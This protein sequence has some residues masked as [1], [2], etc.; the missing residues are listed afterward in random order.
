MNFLSAFVDIRV[1][2][3]K[4]AGQ[5]ARVKTAVTR[6]V[7]RIKSSFAK[8]ATSFKAA[9]DRIVRIAKYGAL[10]LAGALTLAT[11]AA[12]KQEDAQFLLMAALKIS[13]EYTKELEERFKAF[14]ASVQ[15]ATVYGDEEILALMQL[16]KS[17]GVTADKLEL[18][19]KQAIGLATATGRD[20]RSMAMYIA[21]AQQGEFTMLRR[22]IPALRATTDETEQL[23]IITRVCAE[24]FKLAEERAKTASGALRQM[25][26]AVGDVAEVIGGALLPVVKDTAKGVKKWAEDNQEQIKCWAETAVAYIT[27]VKDIL[28]AFIVF[29]TVDWKAG[30]KFAADMGLKVWEA[31]AEKVKS[32]F[33]RL[34]EDLGDIITSEWPKS[35]WEWVREKVVPPPAGIYKP[36]VPLGT[37]IP[38]PEPTGIRAGGISVGP[39]ITGANKV[40]EAIESMV[41]PE[42][43]VKFDEASEKLKMS[44]KGI[45]TTA[46]EV[47]D[48]TKE[49]LVVP[50]EE[51]GAKVEEKEH[52]LNNAMLEH[53]K[54]MIEES[55]TLWEMDANKRI[56]EWE[57]ATAVIR[58]QMEEEEER[59]KPYAQKHDVNCHG[60]K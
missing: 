5:L 8:M 51:A 59:R 4:L 56:M 26:N 29:L 30:L 42:L 46:E 34:G 57:T 28:W 21:L 47:G 19:A 38:L 53:R 36:S 35:I 3:S 45:G 58:Q 13:G 9:W 17:L 12:M 14:A 23:E 22:Y 25:W 2:D 31:F 39:A 6:T 49:A 18:A 7:D 16:Q 10:A 54:E 44:L 33:R 1:D 20:I 37:P 50:L 24:G 60:S 40:R 32:L 52:A 11:R 43:K 15:Q 27:Y 48:Q 55:G 41:P